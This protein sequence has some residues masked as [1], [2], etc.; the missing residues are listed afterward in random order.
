MQINSNIR[1]DIGLKKKDLRSLMLNLPI[2]E[3]LLD[4]IMIPS[5]N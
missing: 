4:R 1:W 2:S 3:R 5:K